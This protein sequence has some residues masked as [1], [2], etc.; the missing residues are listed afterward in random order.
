MDYD[1]IIGNRSGVQWVV[2]VKVRASRKVVCAKVLTN[3]GADVALS[4]GNDDLH[5]WL[6]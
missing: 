4:T 5:F 6:L 1:V 3:M 2:H